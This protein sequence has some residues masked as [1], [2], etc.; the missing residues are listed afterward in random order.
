MIKCP[1]TSQHV[2]VYKVVFSGDSLIPEC[3]GFTSQSN[4]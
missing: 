4:D 1:L 2:F 3:R